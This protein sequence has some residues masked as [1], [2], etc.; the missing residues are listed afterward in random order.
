M[1]RAVLLHEVLEFLRLGP[2]KKILDCTV[3]CGGH[4]REILKR[5]GPRGMLVGIDQDEETLEV[6]ERN[7]K[8]FKDNVIL[9]RENF[10]NIKAVLTKLDIGGL[11][12]V[13]FDLGLSS[14]VL[15]KEERGFSIK[16]NGPLDMRMDRGLKINAGYLVNNLKEFEIAQILREYG[17]ERYSGRIARAIVRKRPITATHELADIISKAVPGGLRKQ[18]IHPATRSFQALR[19]AVNKELDALE[20]TLAF[21]PDFVNRGG[22]ICV[23][24]F[25][26]LEDRIVKNTFRNY[27]NKQT[28]RLITKKPVRPGT[29]EVAVNPRSRSAKLRV[30]E[31]I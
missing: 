23:I 20:N 8:E 13:L 19:I 6:A 25:H 28:L 16:L 12:G 15:E 7:L 11:D 21:I 31:K 5:I 26:S 18:R 1:H 2:G 29:E 30:A 27:K 14:L 17:Q 24:S 22:R 10:K 4:A 3:G 9:I